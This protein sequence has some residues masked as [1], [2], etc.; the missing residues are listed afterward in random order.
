MNTQ[1]KKRFDLILFLFATLLMSL[2]FI[3]YTFIVARAVNT[4]NNQSCQVQELY[5]SY[6]QTIEE[7]EM[8]WTYIENVDTYKSIEDAVEYRDSL[9][10]QLQFLDE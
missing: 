6:R 4:I 9:I 1:M 3:A 8:L 10:E 5:T 7:N 2:L